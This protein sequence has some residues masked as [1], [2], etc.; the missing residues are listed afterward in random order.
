MRLQLAINVT[1]L[2]EGIDF[3]NRLFGT[4]PVK[5]KAGYANYAISEPPLKFVLFESPEAGGSLNHLGI[6]VEDGETVEAIEGRLS[7]SG[8]E[9]SGI[10]DTTCCYAYKTETWVTAPDDV[11]WEVYVKT[12]DVDT[13]EYALLQR[14]DGSDT[15]ET[16][17]ACHC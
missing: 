9:T 5:V 4:T 11:R 6:E 15:A 14:H 7:D 2:E 13:E 1:N 8:L 12:G 16:A 10:D 17:A 3:Y